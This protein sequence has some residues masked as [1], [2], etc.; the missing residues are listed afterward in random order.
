MVL[1]G[2]SPREG[3]SHLLEC[4]LGRYFSDVL[5]GWQLPVGYDAEGAARRVLLSLMS[6][7]MGAWGRTRSPVPPLLVRVVLF[8]APVIFGPVG[9]GVIW[10]RMLVTM[11]LLAPVVAFVLYLVLCSLFKGLNFGCYSCSAG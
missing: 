10:M 7:L 1:L 3:A 5:M 6:G 11:S 4:S 2:Q 9:G 8:I